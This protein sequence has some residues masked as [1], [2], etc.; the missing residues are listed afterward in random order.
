MN[1]LLTLG[2]VWR[3]RENKKLDYGADEATFAKA[4]A[5]EAGRDKGSRIFKTGPTRWPANVSLAYP[6]PLG[7]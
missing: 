5:E 3:W 7:S 6:Y 1:T 4:F 2:L